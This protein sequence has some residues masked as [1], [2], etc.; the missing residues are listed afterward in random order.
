MA[1]VN[2]AKKL[3]PKTINK[4]D[5]DNHLPNKP[6]NANSMTVP[7]STVNDWR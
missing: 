4:G 1:K 7:C 5:I 6:D 3:R 2:V